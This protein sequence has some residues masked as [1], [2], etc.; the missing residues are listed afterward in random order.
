MTP[1]ACLSAA[2]VLGLGIGLPLL[3]GVTLDGDWAQVALWVM[4]G[5]GALAL[6]LCPSRRRA[7]SA[8]RADAA[9][10]HAALGPLIEQACRRHQ[11]S[12]RSHGARLLG[13]VSVAAREIVLPADQAELLLQAFDAAVQ[14]LDRVPLTQDPTGSQTP[15]PVASK[16]LI[17]IE[18]DRLDGETG[19]HARLCLSA[20]ETSLA[21]C[22]RRLRQLCTR[23]GAQLDIVHEGREMQ[24]ELVLALPSA[25]AGAAC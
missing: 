23:L 22:A 20:G 14:L 10:T 11:R 7:R 12:L 25:R 2:V 19:S 16:H 18:L 24:I 15:N 13:T 17:H 21:R 8:R 5:L 3:A 4:A 9:G 1:P 6:L